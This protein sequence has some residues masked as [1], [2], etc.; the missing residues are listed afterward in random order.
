MEE[1]KFHFYTKITL[2]T[3]TNINE[4]YKTTYRGICEIRSR[5]I[6]NTKAYNKHIREDNDCS[7]YYKLKY[8]APQICK[9]CN[10]I[11][12]TEK[13]LETHQISLPHQRQR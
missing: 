1:N 9:I 11:W 5:E 4:D 8:L 13:D 3:N 2:T 12:D 10:A 6:N 7:I